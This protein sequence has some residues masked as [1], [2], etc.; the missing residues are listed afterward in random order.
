MQTEL[1]DERREQKQKQGFS[2]GGTREEEKNDEVP[3]VK[4]YKKRGKRNV[5]CP[6]TK[7]RVITA[8]AAQ[9][10]D[11][12]DVLISDALKLAL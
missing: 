9:V 10:S 5:H 4:L 7:A 8:A 11:G 2:L 1:S 6:V 12:E 3:G